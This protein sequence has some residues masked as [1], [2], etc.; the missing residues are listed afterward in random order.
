VS[1]PRP[2]G[3]AAFAGEGLAGLQDRSRQPHHHLKT[4]SGALVALVLALQRMR[5]PGSQTAKHSD[6]ARPPFSPAAPSLREVALNRVALNR[7]AGRSE[8]RTVALTVREPVI[9]KSRPC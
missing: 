7:Q 4:T 5:L 1:A 2:S 9:K 3:W 8:G 6:L